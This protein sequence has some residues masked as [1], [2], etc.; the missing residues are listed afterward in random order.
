MSI[1]A[2]QSTSLLDAR[3]HRSLEGFEVAHV[4]LGGVD[5]PVVALD[6]IGGL[7]Q[8]LRRRC[9]DQVNRVDLLADVDG[10]DVG[11]L[12]REPHRVRTA[13]TA[14]R[15]GDESDLAFNTSSH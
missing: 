1:M 8:I 15:T 3:V 6:E 9:G 5:P 7:G 10:D 13:L 4:D 12:L 14:R 11:A 2:V